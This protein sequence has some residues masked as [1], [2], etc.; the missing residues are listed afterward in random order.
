MR[1]LDGRIKIISTALKSV[2]KHSV[3]CST[4]V[5]WRRIRNCAASPI[6]I[7]VSNGN[8]TITM[9]EESILHTA[10]VEIFILTPD[11]LL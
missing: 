4:Q 10:T 2:S 11:K 8:F 7:V 9:V 6:P 1:Q 5:E 3:S